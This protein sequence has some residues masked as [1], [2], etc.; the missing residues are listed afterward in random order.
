MRQLNFD[1]KT[2]LAENPERGHVTR[3]DR[4]YILDQVADLLHELGFRRLRGTGLR[5]KHVN[6]LVREWRRQRLSIGTL[7]NRMSV[8]R[9]WAKRIGRPG[10]VGTNAEHG[11]GNRTYVT[12]EDRSRRLD[13]DRLE[14]VT[15]AHVRMSLRLQEV[16]GL[17]REEAIKFT[18]S[19]ADRGDRVVIKASW[20][21]GGR[22][23]EIPIW[24]D[25]QRPV[26]DAARRLA[27]GGA[28]IAG[29]RNYAAQR[30]VYEKQTA[31][32]GLER[33]HGLRHGYAM[34]RYEN[35]TG[36]KAPAAGGPRQ[37]T[38][39]PAMRRIDRS[40]RQ[41]IARELGHHRLSVVSQYIGA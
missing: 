39:S 16:L 37:R 29:G 14:R 23:R 40:A 27:G 28:M 8:L 24:N 4:A 20:A 10:V 7:K 21:K 22:A 30:K 17:R 6:A 9:W 36:W 15:D 5:R 11:I 13:A 33:M 19:Y 26:L 32:A 25:A 38:L 41:R 3:R 18:P 1:L 12:N 31:A 34:D 2:L 35:L